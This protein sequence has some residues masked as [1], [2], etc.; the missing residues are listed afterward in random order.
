MDTVP[1]V[2]RRLA[3]EANRRFSLIRDEAA[4]ALHERRNRAAHQAED[5]AFLLHQWRE[6]DS[7]GSRFYGQPGFA[8][9]RGEDGSDPS[10]FDGDSG[11]AMARV[12]SALGE[13]PKVDP[14]LGTPQVGDANY[15]RGASSWTAVVEWVLEAAGQGVIGLLVTA[16]LIAAARRF[17]QIK[18][19]MRSRR[20]SFL[21]NRG[22]A[23]LIAL[24]DVHGEA[25]S[26]SE[27]WLESAE[28]MSTAAGRELSET[29]YVGADSWLVFIVDFTHSLR[30]VRIISPEGEVAGRTTTSLNDVELMYLPRPHA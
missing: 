29:N 13:V 19:R 30:Y 2:L 1:P 16:P 5:R 4:W 6:R 8:V 12:R 22:G 23:A 27:L 24:N 11:D 17:E 18:Q 21:V 28:E 10:G 9:L 15:G 20:A 7:A 25:P 14:Q 26:D 3:H